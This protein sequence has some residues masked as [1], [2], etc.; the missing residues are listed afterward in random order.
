M[1]TVV[2]WWQRRGFCISH[3]VSIS[4]GERSG[5]R[6]PEGGS[7]L[8]PGSPPRLVT[9]AERKTEAGLGPGEE[10]GGSPR[11]R[12]DGDSMVLP[13]GA[14]ARERPAPVQGALSQPLSER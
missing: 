13:G 7:F 8:Q 1:M 6:N 4:P 9:S 10:L 3:S 2:V 11:Q 5:S 12:E 14:R